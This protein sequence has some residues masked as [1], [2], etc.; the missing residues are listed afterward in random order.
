MLCECNVTAIHV[1]QAQVRGLQLNSRFTL[2]SGAQRETSLALAVLM[3]AEADSVRS[4]P[5]KAQQCRR[6][7]S[8]T[9]WQRDRKAK[10]MQ[11]IVDL[12]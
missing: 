3:A 1:K 11:T 4:F 5:S 8:L 10:R 2:P 7:S 9:C 12:A 6:E